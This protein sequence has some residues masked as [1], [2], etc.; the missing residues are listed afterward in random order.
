MQV[1]LPVLVSS[2]LSVPALAQ[3]P[4]WDAAATPPA[5]QLPVSGQPHEPVGQ[6]AGAGATVLII[7]SQSANG[8]HDQ[9][10]EWLAVANAEGFSASIGSQATLNSTT[11]YAT[12]DVLVIS[13]G[14]ITLSAGAV[15]NIQGFL[16]QGGS[17]YLQGEYL[18]SYATNQAFATIVNGDGGGF[19]VGSTVAGDLQPMAVSGTLSNTPYAT[20]SFSYH[21]YGC[22]GSSGAGVT[23]FM[24]YG[25]SDFGWMYTMASGGRLVHNTDQDWVRQTTNTILCANILYWLCDGGGFSISVQNLV[26]GQTATLQASGATVNGD[27]LSAYSLTGAGPTQTSLG[28]VL[29]SQPIRQLPTMNADAS[30]NAS[31]SQTLPAGTTGLPVWNHA[32]DVSSGTF[33]NGLAL[34][35]G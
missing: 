29:L 14:V 1:S 32:Y 19:A 20:G 21:W 6:P 4:Q 9:D 5:W 11:Y 24:H 16:A 23:P 31:Y 7:E 15:A 30:G 28:P 18:P 25:G 34:V 12:T 26:V 35:I 8:G 22:D 10:I 27:V 13:S 2:L 3:A 33:S 17:V